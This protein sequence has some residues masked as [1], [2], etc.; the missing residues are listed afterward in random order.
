MAETTENNCYQHLRQELVNLTLR[1][2]P[3]EQHKRAWK[4]GVDNVLEVRTIALLASRNVF[5]LLFFFFGI[6]AYDL[7]EAYLE[8]GGPQNVDLA[9]KIVP[10]AKIIL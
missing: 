1:R 7:S 8:D 10:Y 3:S 2:L 6:E 4:N 5:S 9:R